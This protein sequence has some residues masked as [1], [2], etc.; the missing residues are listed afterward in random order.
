MLIT[1]LE[2]VLDS[3]TLNQLRLAK[4]NLYEIVVVNRSVMSRQLVT[5]FNR[6]ALDLK[7]GDIRN[8]DYFK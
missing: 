3:S 2:S 4:L 5:K 7:K 6:K 1:F 8:L